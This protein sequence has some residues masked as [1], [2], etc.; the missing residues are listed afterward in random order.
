MDDVLSPL[1]STPPPE[2]RPRHDQ[3][4]T[5]VLDAPGASSSTMV[6][7]RDKGKGKM[8]SSEVEQFEREQARRV[9]RMGDFGED[10]SAETYQIQVALA[11][12]LLESAESVTEH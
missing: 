10:D 2:K 6:V 4:F 3:L 8:S 9:H 12:S 1:E 5:E 7:P 11:N